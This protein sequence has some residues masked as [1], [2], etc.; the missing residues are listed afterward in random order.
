MKLVAID[1]DPKNLK[2]VQFILADEDIE[3]HAAD[4]PQRGMELVRSLHPDVVLLDL[5]MP[6][7][8]GME[9]LERIVEF[10]PAID[11]ILITGHYSTESAVEAIQKGASDYFPKPLSVEKLQHK[12]RQLAE[13]AKRRQRGMKLETDL[14]ENFEFEGMVGRS[15]LMLELFSKIQRIAPHFRTVLVTGATG[16]GKE[17]VA[18]A[19][20]RASPAHAGPFVALN[21]SAISE[22]LAESELFGHVKGAFTGAQQ[23]K[24]GIF[25]YANG[26]TAMLDE[27]GEMPLAMQAKLLRV[28]QNQEFQ[29]VGSP[30]VRKVD[31]RIVAATNRDV[32]EM[33]AQRKFREDL[34]FR[35]AMVELKI[36][37]LAERFED[38][39][40]LEQH[41]LQHFA[42]QYNKPFAGLTRRARTALGRYS[43]PGNVRE[44]ENVL[45]HVCMMTE[46]DVID[47]RD[48]PERICNSSKAETKQNE[49]LLSMDEMERLHARRVLEH[50]GG[51][52]VRAAQLLGISR[53]HLYE[54]L[55]KN[56]PEEQLDSD[57]EV[58]QSQS[59][60]SKGQ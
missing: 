13:D 2:L 42:A 15:P 17:L 49:S 55:K 54:L 14:L 30:A 35:L 58:L 8:Q 4:D 1:D 19:L 29:R 44:L 12:I 52:K 27:I 39:P 53:T 18:R 3:I 40:L 45:G 11:V 7:V 48:L 46:S 43:W 10:D 22:A 60:S 41:F 59:S 36:P 6:G 56:G 31:V 25:E 32:S 9:M 23:D 24:I 38:L 28:L 47:I 5:V 34:Y 57:A 33:V 51:N 26:G 16:T 21:C 37:P 20:H 50:V